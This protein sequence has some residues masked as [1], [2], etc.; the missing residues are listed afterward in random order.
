MSRGQQVGIYIDA[1]INVQKEMSHRKIP[2]KKQK[3][4]E[5]KYFDKIAEELGK[6]RIECRL[7]I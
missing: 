7:S 5:E 3:L 4:E 6:L 1:L 2:L